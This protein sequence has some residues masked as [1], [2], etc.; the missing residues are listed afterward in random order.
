VRIC[1]SA[2]P[3]GIMRGMNKPHRKPVAALVLVV[4]FGLLLVAGCQ[5]SA[6]RDTNLLHSSHGQ[7]DSCEADLRDAPCIACLKAHCCREATACSAPTSGCS[8]ARKCLAADNSRSCAAAC[9][10][11]DDKAM[12]LCTADHCRRDC[13]GSAP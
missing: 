6:P 12:A 3:W 10:D 2:A 7:Y 11:A 5:S 8:C 1:S 13:P 9:S 4:A